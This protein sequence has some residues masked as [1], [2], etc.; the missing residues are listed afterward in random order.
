M[1]TLY[2]PRLAASDGIDL[3]PRICWRSLAVACGLIVTASFTTPVSA[4]SLNDL[5]PPAVVA[6]PS[7]PAA[8]AQQRV[9]ASGPKVY[10]A[11][12]TGTLGTLD[13]GNGTVKVIGPLRTNASSA[14]IIMT[15]IAFCPGGAL[16]GITFERVYRI[17]ASTARVTLIGSHGVSGLNAL[18]CSSAAR[19]Y[20]SSVNYGRL[21]RVSTS[22]GATTL[23]GATGSF[24][25]AGDLSYHENSL[26][27]TSTDKKLVK[28]NKSNGAPLANKLHNIVDLFGLVSTGTNKLYGFAGTKAY[29]LNE[30]TGAK[31][32]L[33]DFKNKGLQQIFG[34]A[35]NGNFQS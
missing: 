25:S 20:G 24:K 14:R 13:L 5:A 32:Q 9:A 17:N 8:A 34:A 7:A 19:L 1:G 27:L 3:D 30:D 31:T 6:P 15:D 28:L 35:F 22:T 2:G 4:Q 16:Y 23:L 10:L 12:R 29:K 33:F 21:Y 26:F 18:V 11:D